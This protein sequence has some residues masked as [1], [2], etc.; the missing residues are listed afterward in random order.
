MVNW[1][2]GLS[3]VETLAFAVSWCLFGLCRGPLNEDV[4]AAPN[5]TEDRILHPSVQEITEQ[6]YRLLLQVQQVFLP[7][8]WPSKERLFILVWLSVQLLLYWN[9]W[10]QSWEFL[11]LMITRQDLLNWVKA[12]VDVLRISCSCGVLQTNKQK[13]PNKETSKPNNKKPS[14]K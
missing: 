11:A 13:K 4:F 3:V 10:L 2:C 5:Y 6:I 1:N 12:P 7:C 9:F 14:V 8:L